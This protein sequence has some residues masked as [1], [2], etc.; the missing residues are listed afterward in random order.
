MDR[1]T[2][3]SAPMISALIDWRKTQT[4]RVLGG[5]WQTTL[6][7]HD[8]VKT[9][10]APAN[11]PETGTQ[12]WA[13]SGIWAVKHG[14]RGYNRHLGF[15]P[16]RPGDRLWVREAHALVPASSYR[17]SEGVLQTV[18]PADRDRACIYRQGFDRSTGGI[19]WRPSIHMHRW[20]SRM[21]L[22]VTDVRVQRL[23]DIIEADAV[24][25]GCAW[26]DLYEGFTPCPDAGDCRFFGGTA[27]A[28]FA[29]LWASIH[30]P[31]AWDDNPWVCAL[32]F[33]V[34]PRNIDAGATPH[35]RT[36]E[37]P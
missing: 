36:D 18:N 3:F 37:A 7:G 15:A 11:V 35:P 10:F 34:D 5:N 26:S 21:T 6:E 31:G 25:E 24:A 28:S 22:T 16:Y 29:A 14:V 32:T 9:W 1:P 23:Q 27:V 30:G 4:R 2:I 33:T 19:R 8:V 13:E 20:A 12:S 17:M